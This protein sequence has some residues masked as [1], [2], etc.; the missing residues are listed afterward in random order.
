MACRARG[1]LGMLLDYH[2]KEWFAFEDNPATVRNKL[3]ECYEFILGELSKV[4][5]VWWFVAF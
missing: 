3:K 5:V 4:H 2:Y 1:A